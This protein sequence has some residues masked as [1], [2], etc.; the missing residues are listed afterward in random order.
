MKVTITAIFLEQKIKKTSGWSVNSFILKDPGT[1]GFARE[2]IVTVTGSD[3]P[4]YPKVLF[5]LTCDMSTNKKYGAQFSMIAWR[6][7]VD[8]NKSSI[9]NYLSCGII[10]GIGPLLAER[11]Y[12][13]FGNE[14]IEILDSEPEKFMEVPGIPVSKYRMISGSYIKTRGA[15]NAILLLSP[16]NIDLKHII[17]AYRILGP[18]LAT[19]IRQNPYILS[20]M[21]GFPFDKCEEIGKAIGVPSSFPG[22]IRAGIMEVMRRNET[23]GNTCIE[24]EALGRA[25][26]RFLGV[27]ISPIA[28]VFQTMILDKQLVAT[29]GYIYREPTH[30]VEVQLAKEVVRL[31]TSKTW[32]VDFDVD[33]EISKAERALGITLHRN[34]RWGV[35][36]ALKSPV[37][38]ITGGPGTGKTSMMRVLVKVLHEKFKDKTLLMAAPTGKAAR[39]L[40]E[41]TGLDARTVHHCLGIQGG[42]EEKVL[43]MDQ[44]LEQDLVEIDETSML[45][46]WIA[47]ALF[48]SIPSGSKLILVGDVNQLP[49]VGTGDVLRNLI[50][51]DV[52]Q[53]VRLE[54]TFRQGEGSSIDLNCKKMVADSDQ[55]EWDQKSRFIPC[56]PSNGKNEDPFEDM[57]KK[58]EEVYLKEVKRVGIDNVVC[59]CP[60][61]ER[62]AAS[63]QNMNKRIQAVMNP[64][65]KGITFRGETFKV[66]DPV[67]NLVNDEAVANGD[68]GKVK[69]VIEDAEGKRVLVEFPEA[70]KEYSYTELENLTLA[71]AM[72]VHKSQGS[73]Y[74]VVLF[75]LGDEHHGMKKRNIAYTAAS[76]AKEVFYFFGTE[77]ALSEAIHR[78]DEGR[79]TL[80]TRRLQ[81]TYRKYRETGIL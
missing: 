19:K 71:Y 27:D 63:S 7:I 55:M 80:L 50:D 33:E 17:N 59:L 64:K 61:R 13:R 74:K 62:G 54:H 11:I 45:D 77:K 30:R 70:K 22:R 3:V 52:C 75:C 15:R 16:F 9:V 18:S 67:M 66:G 73:E 2:T 29:E 53:V 81:V 72:T 40:S 46:I 56:S 79:A 51:S 42:V 49:S 25:C 14:A 26:S 43:E 48:K 8:K 41:S 34:Q 44:K 28:M 5:E 38:I 10:D 69:D 60:Y 76:R 20:G 31:A 32:K 4:A 58:M 78:P 57:A 36:Q 37:V 65:A 35:E 68:V 1:S 21:P 24:K 6:E 23:C 47:Y 39:R 12:N